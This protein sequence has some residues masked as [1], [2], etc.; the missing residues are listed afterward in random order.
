MPCDIEDYDG[1]NTR[2]GIYNSLSP[3]SPCVSLSS[4][5][6]SH[7]LYILLSSLNIEQIHQMGS[8]SKSEKG[9]SS[10]SCS[11]S[12]SKQKDKSRDAESDAQPVRESSTTWSCH[13]CVGVDG[14]PR[15]WGMSVKLNP[16]CQECNHER[17]K[18]CITER[19]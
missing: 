6:S 18:K 17:C 14:I 9:M 3:F 10:G 1:G 5:K 11:G 13:N 15:S 8:S 2:N 19:P 12:K 4:I 16:L 7:C